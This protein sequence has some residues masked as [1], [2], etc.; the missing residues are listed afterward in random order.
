ME[1]VESTFKVSIPAGPIWND[2]DGKLK[3]PI[4]AAAHQGKFD[5]NWRTVVPGEMSTVDV[6]LDTTVEGKH[7]F[8]TFLLAGPIWNNDDAKEKCPVICASYGGTWSGEWKTIT[9]GVMS[10]CECV[11]KY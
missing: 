8:K 1:K 7:E 2:A 9:E 6:I 10:V 3:G 4:V 5:G 11:F